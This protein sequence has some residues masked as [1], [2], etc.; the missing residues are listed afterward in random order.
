M[1][2]SV[3]CI[4]YKD[5]KLLIAK[6]IARGD[7]GGRWEFPGGKIDGDED[8]SSAIT[9]EM[10]EEFGIK[11]RADEKICAAS[12]IHHGK[13]CLVTAYRV[14]LEH[15]G[16]QAPFKLSEHTEYEW[17]SADE[18]PNRPFVDSDLQLYPAVKA[19]LETLK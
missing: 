15:D 17:V 13:E 4:V 19:Y 7:M 16:V 1:S 18:I 6:R 11:A 3:A 14:H 10:N 12:F 5:G 9:R 2:R 8:A